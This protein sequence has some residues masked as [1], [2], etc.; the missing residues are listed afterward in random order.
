MQTLSTNHAQW[1]EC[2]AKCMDPKW[3][4]QSKSIQDASGGRQYPCGPQGFCYRTASLAGSTWTGPRGELT[5][6]RE[7]VGPTFPCARSSTGAWVHCL[8]TGPT[9]S[10]ANEHQLPFTFRA[11]VPRHEN[12]L[13]TLELKQLSMIVMQLW[14]KIKSKKERRNGTLQH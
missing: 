9:R 11:L 4:P 10:R 14:W 3:T 1:P 6:C 13:V 2:A 5:L 7:P 12:D 8:R